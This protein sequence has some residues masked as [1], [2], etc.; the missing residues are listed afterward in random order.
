MVQKLAGQRPRLWDR[1]KSGE[2]EKEKKKYER[3]REDES[4][5]LSSKKKTGTPTGM[6]RQTGLMP[7]E[8]VRGNVSTSQIALPRKRVHRHPA[9]TSLPTTQATQTRNRSSLLREKHLN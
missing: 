7:K 4:R 9:K 2:G 8:E 5:V 3:D 1:D 6:G